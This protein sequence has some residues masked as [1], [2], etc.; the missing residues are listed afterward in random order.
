[1]SFNEALE[2]KSYIEA[3]AIYDMRYRETYHNYQ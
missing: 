3:N 1:M 2:I